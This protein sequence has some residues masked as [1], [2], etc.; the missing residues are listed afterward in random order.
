MCVE[1][2]QNRIKF[3]KKNMPGSWK[4]IYF[5]EYQDDVEDYEHSIISYMLNTGKN[6]RMI[7]SWNE[8]NQHNSKQYLKHFVDI[9]LKDTTNAQ[10]YFYPRQSNAR[11]H[12]PH[13]VYGRK[14]FTSNWV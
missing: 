13:S 3:A 6:K 12:S 14:L 5:S 10:Q 9:L 4:T 11:H 7:S 8:I 1:I 2:N